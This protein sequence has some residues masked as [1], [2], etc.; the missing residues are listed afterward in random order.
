MDDMPKMPP[1]YEVPPYRDD[2]AQRIT[3]SDT[4]RLV[5]QLAAP[6]SDKERLAH[7]AA[8]A[9]QGYIGNIPHNVEYQIGE[10]VDDVFDFAEAMVAEFNRRTEGGE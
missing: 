1:M 6:P 9:M 10:I 3:V 2:P 4:Q 8:A 5:A 7:F